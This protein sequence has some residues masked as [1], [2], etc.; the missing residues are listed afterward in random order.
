MF[1]SVAMFLSV[2]LYFNKFVQI[3]FK[4]E[5]I[6]KQNFDLKEVHQKYLNKAIKFE[7]NI[8]RNKI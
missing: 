5:E 3:Y 7:K 1:Y 2:V 4:M 6:L 8:N